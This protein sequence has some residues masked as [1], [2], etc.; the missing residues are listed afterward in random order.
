MFPLFF[1]QWTTLVSRTFSWFPRRSLDFFIL[2]Q[3]SPFLR[4]MSPL[5]MR[6][7]L[8]VWMKLVLFSPPAVFS[9]RRFLSLSISWYLFEDWDLGN[10]V[11]AV[12]QGQFFS[13]LCAA[14]MAACLCSADIWAILVEGK[15][16]SICLRVTWFPT[17]SRELVGEPVSFWQAVSFIQQSRQ[18]SQSFVSISA[19]RC[20]QINRDLAGKQKAAVNVKAGF[21]STS[22][23][24]PYSSLLLLSHSSS[25]LTGL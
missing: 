3:F 25:S 9:C 10:Q 19:L 20:R 18:C 4:E 16:L 21:D 22:H 14:S 12:D 15:K 2:A 11:L 6:P 17:D 23:L 5:F 24:T 7:S 8:A 13:H 1:P